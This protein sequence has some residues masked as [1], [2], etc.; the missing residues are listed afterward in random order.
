MISDEHALIQ[1]SK[2]VAY[3]SAG[4][5]ILSGLTLSEWGVIVGIVCWVL[6]TLANQYWA[7]RKSKREELKDKQ[8]MKLRRDAYKSLYKD[9]IKLWQDMDDGYESKNT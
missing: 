8:L 6:S 9:D 1:A 4:T 3:S 7:W 2:I 5:T